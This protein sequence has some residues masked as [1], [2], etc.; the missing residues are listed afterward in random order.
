MTKEDA[1]IIMGYTG[2]TTVPFG[3]FCEDVERR[4]G[5]SVFTHQFGDEN[6][7]KNTIEPLCKEDFLKLFEGLWGE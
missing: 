1:I 7:V 3:L 6:F 5:Y 4:L 2:I